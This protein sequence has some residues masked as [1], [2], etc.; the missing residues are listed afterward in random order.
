LE[1]LKQIKHCELCGHKNLQEVLN[2]GNHP[3]CDDLIPIS[4]NRQCTSYPITILLCQNCLTAHQKFQI[5]KE[6]LFPL[7]YHYRARFTKDVLNGM[8]NLVND[9]EKFLHTLQNVKV[10]DVGCN[11]GSLLNFFKKKGSF[12]VGIEPTKA[13]MDAT[14]AGHKIY[15]EFF[16]ARLAEK[17]FK[18]ESLFDVVVFTNVFAHIDDLKNLLLN[19]KKV[20][21][22]DGLLIIE[23]HYLGSVLKGNQFDTFYHEHPRTYSAL[24]FIHIAKIL[25]LKLTDFK[26]TSRYGGNIRVFISNKENY[27]KDFLDKTI[28][29]EKETF[30]CLFLKMNKFINTWKTEINSK[31]KNIIKKNGPLVAKAFPGRAAILIHLLGYDQRDISVVYEKPNSLKIDHFVPGTRIPI[32]SEKELFEKKEKHTHLLNLAWHI[33]DEIDSYMKENKFEG[34]IINILE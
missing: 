19:I 11:D 16:D 7:N 24:S 5:R 17:V 1:D 22:K 21:K 34:K 2:I 8:E 27:N 9:C 20:L 6:I 10:L 3:L 4:S 23:N 18:Q 13:S 12:T 30:E 33:P 32:K 15:N 31:L 14:E 25:G 26:F 28:K 29:N